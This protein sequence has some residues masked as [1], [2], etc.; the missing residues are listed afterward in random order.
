MSKR[1]ST[2]QKRCLRCRI[3]HSLC[4]CEYLVPIE[5]QNRVSIIMHHREEHLTS[6]TATLANKILSNSQLLIRG[7]PERPF[8]FADLNCQDSEL[9]LYLYPHE[10]ALELNSENFSFSNQK[11]HLIVPDGSWAQARKVYRRE[12]GMEKIQCVKLPMGFVSEYRLRKT[13][14]QD[15][16]STYEAIAR[17]LG[18]M[19]NTE[20]ENK[21]MDM[22]RIMVARMVKSRTTFHNVN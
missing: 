6:N 22:F 8:N 17:A 14:I 9:A 13:H 2:E 10:N 15:G 19:E 11:I 18:I 7:L 20:V 16:L 12:K 3:H 1:R 4:F 21:M 5:T